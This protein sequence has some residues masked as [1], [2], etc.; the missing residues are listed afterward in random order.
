SQLPQLNPSV[1]YTATYWDASLHDPERLALDLLRD[2]REAGGEQARTANYTGAV[3]AE[4][5][6]VVLRDTETG[7][8]VAFAA[9]V[10]INASGPWTDITN[11]ALDDPTRYMGGTKGSHIVIDDPALLGAT[12]GRELFFEHKDGRIV[13]IYPL[14]GRVL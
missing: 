6:K 11:T 1:K 13:L 12:G 10:I 5:G 2:G 4:G 9:S 3:G 8:E 14:K 7:D